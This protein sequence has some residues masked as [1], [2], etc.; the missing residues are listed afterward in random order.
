MVKSFAL[1]R[2]TLLSIGESKLNKT[3]IIL[4][5]TGLTGNILLNKLL[6]DNRYRN[7]KIFTRSPL[8]FENP[9]VTE[10]LCDLFELDNYKENFHGDEVFCCIGT[11]T[12]KTP[13]KEL[14]KKID[15]GIP[16]SAA[17]LCKINGIK[18]I[19]I[20]SATGANAKSSIFYNRT[21]GEMEEAVLEQKIE[22]TFIL[23]PSMIGGNRKEFRIAEKI[24]TILMKVLN[25]LFVGSLRKYRLIDAD[26][27]ANAMIKLAN[28]GIDEQIIESDRIQDL[29]R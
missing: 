28:N 26:I 16:V 22:N 7:I 17:K 14:Y 12:K 8:R 25:P 19:A 1:K 23:R 9:K 3:A 24:G 4:G 10:I 13:D 27:I 29:G 18:T 11:T 5:A 21:K 15:L 6:G 20:I 2:W